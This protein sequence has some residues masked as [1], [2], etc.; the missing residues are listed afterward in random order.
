MPKQLRIFITATI[1]VHATDAMAQA[2]VTQAMRDAAQAVLI[3]ATRRGGAADVEARIVTVKREQAV[4]L[5]PAATVVPL[6]VAVTDPDFAEVP[7]PVQVAISA[8]AAREMV[9]S[10]GEPPPASAGSPVD[11]VDVTT[12]L[13]HIPASLRR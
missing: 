8:T 4:L 13:L 11:P 2:Q 7:P 5:G 6:P 10:H 3:S 9:G 12:D 1:P